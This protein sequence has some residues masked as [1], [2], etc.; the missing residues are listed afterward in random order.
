VSLEGRMIAVSIGDAPDRGRLGYPQRE[1]DRVL[2]SVCTALVRAGARIV[3]GG[4]LDPA[5]FTFKIFRHLSEAYAV[6]RS[7]APFVHVVPEPVLRRTN[8]E[9]LASMLKEARGTVETTIAFANERVARLTGEDDESLRGND[10]IGRPAITAV[11]PVSNSDTRIDSQESLEHWLGQ[12][13]ANPADVYSS[14]RRIM[15]RMVTGRVVMGGRMGVLNQ[16]GDHYEGRMPGIL[17]EAILTLAHREAL[18]ILGA[19][20]G[21]ARD[22]AI[23]LNLLEPSARVPRGPQHASYNQ[24]LEEARALADRIP[25]REDIRGQLS[26]IAKSDRAEQLSYSVVHLLEQW[27]YEPQREVAQ[28]RQGNF[29][30]GTLLGPFRLPDLPYH[31]DALAPHMSRETLEYHHSKHHL[32]Y[33][34]NANNVIKGTEW[35]GKSLEDVVKGSFGKNAGLFNNAGQHYNHLH[36]WQW[37]KPKG[38]GDKLPGNLAKKIVADLGSIAKMKEEFIQAGVTQFGSGWA[39]LAVKDGK[40]IVTKTSNGENPLVHGGKPILGCD[41]WEHSYYLDYRNRRPD[42]LKAFLDYLVNWEY[43]A[44]MYDAAMK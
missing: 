27:P 6:R 4:N 41:V 2:L 26:A 34:Q 37:M 28:T 42:Y 9:D 14:A 40:I 1:V 33:V 19:F 18:V 35:E 15:T 36:F 44:K 39:W 10:N 13:R 8:F 21:A 38:G 25:D 30:R 5:G 29:G 7:S 3:Y 17:E 12:A 16:P 32:A 11:D 31:Y 22:L 23:A 43:V 20:G 24:G